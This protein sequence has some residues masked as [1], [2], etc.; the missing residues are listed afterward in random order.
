MRFGLSARHGIAACAI[1]GLAAALYLPFL[2][3]PLVF[4]DRIFFSGR[5]FSYYATHPIGLDLRLPAY[6]SIVA[7][8]VLWGG[9]ATHRGVSLVL[10]IACAL[11]LYRLLVV[12]QRAALPRV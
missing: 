3:N 9:I 2:G 8:E 11:A 10:H 7:T 4:D 6:F 5:L 1:A 12:L